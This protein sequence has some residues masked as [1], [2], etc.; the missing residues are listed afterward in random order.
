M[1]VAPE[2]VRKLQ[3]LTNRLD[4]ALAPVSRRGGRDTPPAFYDP[5]RALEWFT[6]WQNIHADLVASDAELADIPFRGIPTPEKGSDFDGRGLIR[7]GHVDRMRDDISDVWDILNHPTRQLTQFS[8]DR[9]GIFVAGQQFDAML[10]IS[11]IIKSAKTKLVLVDGYISELT[12]DLLGQKNSP[13]AVEIL[14]YSMTAAVTAH[15]TAFLSQHGGIAIRTSKAFHDR[16]V[17]VDDVDC[18]H[19][20][21]SI[22]DAARKSTFMFSRIEEPFVISALKAELV[23]AW[24]AATQVAL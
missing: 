11:G 9:E 3:A 24:A 17:I 22:K 16:F 14:T 10:A 20:G 1:P 12:L 23:Q 4:E 18:F 6:R 19:F 5:Q 15:A 7:R 13:V 21:H 2:V 8:I